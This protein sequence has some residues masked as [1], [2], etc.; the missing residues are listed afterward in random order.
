MTT[1]T[2]IKPE[3]TLGYIEHIQFFFIN[4]VDK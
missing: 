3:Q 4:S 1:K 2:K